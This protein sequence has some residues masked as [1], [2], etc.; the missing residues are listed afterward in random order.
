MPDDLWSSMPDGQPEIVMCDWAAMLKDWE[1]NP[2]Q[3]CRLDG[4]DGPHLVYV[5]GGSKTLIVYEV[6]P[7]LQLTERMH[8]QVELPLDRESVCALV[9]LFTTAYDRMG[10]DDA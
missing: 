7:M 1:A 9:E 2:A 8:A 5:T 6:S 3:C 4:H 10:D